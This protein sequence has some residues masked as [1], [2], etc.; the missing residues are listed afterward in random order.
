MDD[1]T[2]SITNDKI[3]QAKCLKMKRDGVITDSLSLVLTFD[4]KKN[5]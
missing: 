4:K 1:V 3:K 5:S 2:E